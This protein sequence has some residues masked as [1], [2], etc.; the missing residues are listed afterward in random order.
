NELSELA[1]HTADAQREIISTVQAV[2]K[3]SAYIY[4][5][6]SQQGRGCAVMRASLRVDLPW[7]RNLSIIGPEGKI[8]CSTSQSIV[9]F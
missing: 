1:K 5:A 9:G 3:S 8:D 4:A 6:A 2:V 7:I